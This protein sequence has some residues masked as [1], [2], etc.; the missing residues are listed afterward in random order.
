MSMGQQLLGRNDEGQSK[1]SV[2]L[3]W[4]MRAAAYVL[5]VL[6]LTL[7]F[8]FD[9]AVEPT[10]YRVVVSLDMILV[11]GFLLELAWRIYASRAHWLRF[12]ADERI[13]VLV[14]FIAL[15]LLHQPRIAAVVVIARLVARFLD[16]VL[17]TQLAKKAI[18]A[19]NLHPSQTLALSFVGLILFGTI[20]LLFPAATVNGRGMPFF[21][22]LFT[23]TSAACVVGLSVV[24]FTSHFTFFGQAVILVAIQLGGLGIMLLSVAFAVLVGGYVPSRRE[25]GY[26][27]MFD[28]TQVEGLKAL[29]ASVAAT[30]LVAEGIGVLVLFFLWRDDIPF[31]SERLWWAVFH[32]ISAFCNAGFSLSPNSLHR[33]AD[34]PGVLAVVML[35]M[36]VGGLGFFVVRDLMNANVWKVFQPMAIWRR[37]HVQTKVVLLATLVL[38]LGGM[39]IF[40]FLEFDGVLREFA[41]AAKVY[42]AF[43]QSVAPRTSGF[44]IVSVSDLGPA[45]AFF[46]MILMFI[47]ASPGST[48]GGVKTTT[49][50]VALAALRAMFL[51]R[52]DVELMGRRVPD[53][54]VSRSL[55]III[56]S[57]IVLAVA[58][59]GLVA[60]QAAPFEHLMFEA[61]SA[62][63]TVGLSMNTTGRLSEGGKILIIC[64]MYIGRIGPLTMALAVGGRRLRK[65]FQYPEER[66][67]VG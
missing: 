54:T 41:P 43:F 3:F 59:M 33:F 13:D 49:A 48:G 38:D 39:L 23:M 5:A 34:S 30:T 50:A 1:L 53:S 18:H 64:L 51:A 17:E 56:V 28:V 16:M 44:S 55:S 21:D 52:D 58:L 27:E 14:A 36:T 29:V 20:L 40:L 60:T 8:C 66:I 57:A 10:F 19:A 22:A 35:L 26:K 12:I 45:T 65:G 62:F 47:G 37:L 25:A 42:A 32:S 7:E 24:D 9:V 2:A 67:A 15:L 46:V 63:S 61:V 31:V 11:L 4:L 6:I